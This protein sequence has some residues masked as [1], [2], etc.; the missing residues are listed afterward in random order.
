MNPSTNRT[1]GSPARRA[2]QRGHR[3]DPR[4]LRPRV[5][6]VEHEIERFPVGVLPRDAPAVRPLG[7]VPIE[8]A[9]LQRHGL[10]SP[11]AQRGQR[12]EVRD[13]EGEGLIAK[14]GRKR[15][16]RFQLVV[17][18]SRRQAPPHV[19][20]E[21]HVAG[22]PRAH[23]RPQRHRQRAPTVAH[24]ARQQEGGKVRMASRPT[25]PPVRTSARVRTP[26]S[27]RGMQSI[28]GD[29]GNAAHCSA[30]T[31]RVSPSRSLTM[32]LVE[33]RN[34]PSHVGIIMD[35][36]GRWAQ[37]RGQPRVAGHKEGAR[38]PSV[39]SFA[40][41]AAWG[42]SALTLY[43]F[44][45]QN[46][47]RPEEEVDALMVLLREF[48]LSERD[49]ILDNGIRLNAIGNLG[50]LP[51]ARA[52]RARPAPRARARTTTQMTLT[53]ALSYG[54][55]EEIAAA[56]RELAEE[57]A[58]RAHRPGRRDD[59]ASP[60]AHAE[61][62][63]SAT[64]TSSSAP[65]ASGASRTSSSTASPTP[66]STSRTCSGPT[67]ART[68]STRRSRATRCASAA[69]ATSEARAR[70]GRTS[71]PAVAS[72]I[73]SA[74]AASSAPIT[75]IAIWHRR[76]RRPRTSRCGSRRPRC[77]CRSSCCSST[78]GR[79]GGSI[80][81]CSRPRSIGTLGALR[82][83]PP[84]RPRLAGDRRRHRRRAVAS[85][86]TS[87]VHDARIVVT[88]LV[89]VPLLGPLVTL[90]RLGVDRDRPAFR[91]F[92]MGFGPLFV[93]VPLTL[94]ALL[95]VEMAA[96]GPSYVRHDDDVRV[97]GRHR[98]LLRRAASWASTSSTRR[99]RPRR[100]SRGPSGGSPRQR[101]SGRCWPFWYLPRHAARARRP[102]GASSAGRSGRRA[103]SASR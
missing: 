91:A 81:S 71:A 1:R 8:R 31:P 36:N 7:A 42:C 18:G 34:L 45:E 98:R 41:R 4:A 52:R 80:S 20:R 90:A 82:D 53:L 44:S 89:V 101:R 21:R 30:R 35:G 67:S 25:F 22:P 12:R 11:G 50:R 23:E 26:V 83:D 43:A 6:D 77:A 19:R 48:L 68:T 100:R 70:R 10:V 66:S 29:S 63:P 51:V 86:C 59:R 14:L 55:R 15:D 102:A 40:P 97:V 49:E 46:W 39:A 37:L 94:L 74:L 32:V 99:C 87:V 72:P 64:P 73:A 75:R 16:V 56:A 38:R 92:A 95:R 2:A 78:E 57:V 3:V 33:A 84:G 28:A 69:S 79:R 96:D 60:L 5:L 61:P 88:V 58:R 47:A 24:A 27:M 85:R 17:R 76:W 65:A 93:A 62:R 13:A 9:R 103:T 54:G